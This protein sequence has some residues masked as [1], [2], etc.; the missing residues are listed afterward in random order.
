MNRDLFFTKL[1]TELQL[2]DLLSEVSEVTGG[3]THKMYK[4]ETKQGRYIV[5]LL[6]PHIMKRATALGN[7]KRADELEEILRKHN[8]P[9][10]PS[11]NFNNNKMQ[12]IDG[13][14]FYVY[15]WYSGLALTGK[16]IQ[17]NNCE[18]IGSVLANIHNIDIRSE[19]YTR[20]EINIDWNKY[21]ELS[22]EQGSPIFSLLKDKEIL[23]YDSQIKG[24]LA[25]KNIPDIISICHNDLDSKNVLWVNDS[26]KIIDLECLNYSNPYLELLEL[27]LCWSGYE[28]CNIKFDYLKAFINAYFKD[29]RNVNMDW[30]TLYYS[31]YGRL[32][33]LEYNVKRAL[34]LECDT[35]D[36]Q[37]LGINQV[38]ETISHVIYYDSIKSELIEILS[39][40]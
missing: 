37:E 13:Q 12:E 21:I 36:E 9:I 28:E 23:L 22:K 39:I 25:I 18:I 2:G 20:D 5:K 32:E 3:L 17:K 27:A 38:K 31:N 33:W 19:K 8:I 1:S 35:K 11:L 10:I 7:F 4:F 15:E 29:N 34:L 14:F 30:E 26:F 40:I 24:N 6:N 16:E